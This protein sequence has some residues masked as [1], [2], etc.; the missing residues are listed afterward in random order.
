MK[1]IAYTI[2]GSIFIGLEN[3]S[4]RQ[5]KDNHTG[6]TETVVGEYQGNVL[7]TQ[8]RITEKGINSTQWFDLSTKENKRRFNP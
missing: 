6:L 8:K 7:L 3:A 2:D 5:I 1:H 4:M